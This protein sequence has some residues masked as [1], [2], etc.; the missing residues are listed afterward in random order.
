MSLASLQGRSTFYNIMSRYDKEFRVIYRKP[1]SRPVSK[2]TPEIANKSRDFTKNPSISTRIVASK[3]KTN[4]RTLNWIKVHHLG[5]KGYR[6]SFAPKY[7][8]PE[9]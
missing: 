5:I 9:D 3:L 6:K 1:S 2:S 4:P 8:G 7:T